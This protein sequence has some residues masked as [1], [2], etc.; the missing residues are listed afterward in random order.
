MAAGPFFDNLKVIK[1]DW[2][3]LDGGYGGAI[4]YLVPRAEVMN[5]TGMPSGDE[6]QLWSSFGLL[7]NLEYL[8][9][10]HR[11][12]IFGTIPTEL[13]L[14]AA[15]LELNLANLPLVTGTIP[16][17]LGLLTKLTKLDLS[18]TANVGSVP[19]ELC[20]RWKTRGLEVVAECEGGMLQC[21]SPS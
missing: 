6:Y 9:H 20:H 15:L 10:A 14:M 11:T 16:S 12:S 21:C 17:E 8:S 1:L 18:G 3:Q 4:N 7:T 19:N 13:G 5:Y 2:T